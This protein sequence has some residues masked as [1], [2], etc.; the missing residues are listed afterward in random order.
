M[1]GEQYEAAPVPVAVN[2]GGTIPQLAKGMKG[3]GKGFFKG[4]SFVARPPLQPPPPVQVMTFSKVQRVIASM[5]SMAASAPQEAAAASAPPSASG[6]VPDW[7]SK[8]NI[9]LSR[10][11]R[12]PL[13]KDT[14]QF[15]V[16]QCLEGY[17]ATVTVCC[18][19]DEAGQN[20]AFVGSPAVNRK[21]AEQLACLEVLRAYAELFELEPHELDEATA[22]APEAPSQ[23]AL[24][25]WRASR[26]PPE[27]LAHIPSGADS[28]K[29][30]LN[31]YVQAV[32]R[33]APKKG[34]VVFETVPVVEGGFQSTIT[35][36]SLPKGH[37]GQ[38]FIGEIARQKKDAEQ[39]A[40]IVANE[41]LE[42]VFPHQISLPSKVVRRAAA[43]FPAF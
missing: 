39:N 21:N 24:T 37:A 1:G 38:A 14:L 30:M 17:Q 25:S 15:E 13:P 16:E 10:H 35:L 31:G 27:I 34:E 19:E 5:A 41:W 12:I 36:R 6:K 43:S 33:R 22:S 3:C 40:A 23:P 29:C 4:G 9:A 18:F 11:L 8:L 26:P 28:P 20:H 42:Q 32:L 7:R 2:V